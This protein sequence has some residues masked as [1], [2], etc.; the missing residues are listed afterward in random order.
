MPTVSNSGTTIWYDTMGSGPPV[1]MVYGIGGNS[2]QWWEEFPALLARKFTLVMLD[3][4]GTG[5]SDKPETPW[6]MSDM[7]GDIQAVIDA[8]GLD[9]FHLLGCSL[10][11]MIARHFVKERGG[12]KLRSLSLLCPPNGT[13]AKEEDS[14]AAL[15]WDRTKPA[16]ENA[17]GGWPII[18]PE[19]WIAANEARLIEKLEANLK[20]PTPPITYQHQLKAAQDAGDANEAVN[21][22]NWPV[23]IQ[24]GTADRLVPPVNAET[25]K[26]AIPRAQLHM[27]E[28]ASH[29]FWQHEP[30]RSAA[31]VTTFLDAAEARPEG[32]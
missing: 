10:G 22:Y 23:L 28:G 9:T 26:A 8:V 13:P 18:H 27:M 16:L 14:K 32:K 3:N 4:R 11:S 6:T 15:F 21:D 1:V 12:A 19:P 17:R 30:E 7:T 5:F 2:R 25:L 20:N 29:N 24:H 31:I